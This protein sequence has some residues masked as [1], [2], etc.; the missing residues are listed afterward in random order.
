MATN[1][2]GSRVTQRNVLLLKE[3]LA[4]NRII[5]SRYTASG[6]DNAEFALSISTDP[7]ESKLFRFPLSNTHIASAIAGADIPSNTKRVRRDSVGECL[8][9]TARVQE[10]EE[11]V[12]KLSATVLNMMGSK[13]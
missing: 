8:G 1:V 2:K 11:Q 10:L 6:L 13:K 4:L 9:L 12:K 5:V 7:E 3:T